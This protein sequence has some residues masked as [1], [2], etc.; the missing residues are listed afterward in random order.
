MLQICDVERAG[1]DTHAPNA[2]ITS[3]CNRVR[4]CD[5]TNHQNLHKAKENHATVHQQPHSAMPTDAQNAL[6]DMKQN[7]L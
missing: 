7:D 2:N 5:F 6:A 3:V 4:I 1:I